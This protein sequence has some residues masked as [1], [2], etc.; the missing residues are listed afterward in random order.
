MGK[1][2]S[3]LVRRQDAFLFDERPMELEGFRLKARSVDVIGR[4]T[5]AQFAAA[6]DFALGCGDG[7]PY[8]IGALWNYGEGRA[9]WRE[10]LEQ[11]IRSQSAYTHKS[12]INLGY[13][14]RNTSAKARDLAPSVGHVSEVASLEPEEQIEWMERSAL[15]GLTV[16]ELRLE[17]K[18]SRRR[19]VLD[20]RA[21]LEGQHR[22]IYAD[23]PWL[24]GD[25]PPSGSG[26][27][28]HFPGMTIEQ[29]CALPIEAH[30]TPDAVLFMWTTAPL[31]L[32]NPGV[33]EVIEAWGF[34]YKT[35]QIW[36]KVLPAGGFYVAVRH[37]ILL[38]ATR[39]S[40]T[41]DHP[42]PMPTSV[43]TERQTGEH[44]SKPESFRQQIEKMYEGP[45]L[46][47][48]GR[49]LAPGWTVFGNDA[50]LWQKQIEAAVV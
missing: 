17:I 27:Q 42:V 30:A 14:V 7:S 39:G 1:G 8:W 46:E 34:K 50:R 6:L 47:L 49:T 41:P 15:E 10:K 36:D 11:S 12:L 43:I 18:A 44:S 25:R 33:R 48:F 19:Q 22:V 20:G 35:C 5:L 40:C 21:V 45:Y 32:E 13:I 31:I 28:Q 23:P 4:P 9:D 24:Y 38:I 16:R 26:A 3:D 2:P 37:E 29:L